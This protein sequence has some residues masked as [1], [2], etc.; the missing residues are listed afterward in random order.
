MGMNHTSNK[1]KVDGTAIYVPSS[2]TIENDN[3]VSSDSGRTESGIMYINWIRPT[4][5][6]VKLTYDH[7][8]GA[9]VAFLH[10]LMQGREFVFVYEDNG[11]K[12]MNAYAGKDSYSQRN[13]SNY[14]SA[15]GEYTDYSIDIIEI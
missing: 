5:R 12:S 13:L 3:I 11:P 14:A 10:S 8:T 1:W 4:V 9:E 7:I 2:V 6:K 15:G